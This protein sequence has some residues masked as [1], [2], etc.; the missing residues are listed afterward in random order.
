MVRPQELKQHMEETGFLPTAANAS[1]D[2]AVANA[3]QYMALSLERIDRSLA[4]IAD[5]LDKDST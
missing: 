3:L 2:D 1:A 5:H 4:R